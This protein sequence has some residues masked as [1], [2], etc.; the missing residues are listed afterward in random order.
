MQS[1]AKDISKKINFQKIMSDDLK[2]NTAYL[3]DK[4]QGN[5]Y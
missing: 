1:S 3:I 4:E 2:K 5:I